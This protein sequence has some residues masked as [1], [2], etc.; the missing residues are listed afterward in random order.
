MTYVVNDWYTQWGPAA[1][2]GTLAGTSVG[3]SLLA[4][5]MF[6]FGKVLR[7]W[8]AESTVLGWTTR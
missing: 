2:F 4:L 8:T 1:F 6:V 7:Q 3:L 5:P